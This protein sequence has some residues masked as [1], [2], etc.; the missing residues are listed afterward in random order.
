M[1]RSAQ[2]IDAPRTQAGSTSQRFA[3]M[4]ANN[5]HTDTTNAGHDPSSLIIG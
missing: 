5:Y 2:M 1:I 4:K 3:M